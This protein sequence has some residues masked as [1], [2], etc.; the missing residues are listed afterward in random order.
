MGRHTKSVEKHPL[1]DDSEH[2]AVALLKQTA[3]SD[4]EAK[5][6]KESQLRGHSVAEDVTVCLHRVSSSQQRL[7]LGAAQRWVFLF[8]HT[9]NSW[10]ELDMAQSR[11]GSSQA[12]GPCHA[13][14][15]GYT[16]NARNIKIATSMQVDPTAVISETRATCAS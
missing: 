5:P 13:L 10:E 2:A 11:Q 3:R 4:R 1:D 16:T 7:R 12:N 8:R 14:V 15:L 9:N 6:E